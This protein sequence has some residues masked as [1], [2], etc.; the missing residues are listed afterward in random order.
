MV[1]LRIGISG[2]AGRMGRMLVAEVAAT[3]DCVLAGGID[4]PAGCAMYEL[5]H[6]AFGGEDHAVLARIVAAAQRRKADIA[7]LTR[8]GDAVAHALAPASKIDV[9]PGRGCLAERKRCAGGRVDLVAV[10]HLDDFD[11]VI[12]AQA[13]RRVLDEREEPVDAEA[14]IGRPENRRRFRR[15][16]QRLLRFI[17][18]TG[19]A[20]DEG[21]LRLRG[22][23]K[24]RYRSFRR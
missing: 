12:V 6:L 3:E 15:R 19:G 21:L 22:K 24:M 13:A 2:C 20:D 17:V 23:S 14:H 8:A 5:D 16:V 18:E 7:A 9:A 10:M 4:A 11:V 1:A